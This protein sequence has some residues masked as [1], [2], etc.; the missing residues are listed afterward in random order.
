MWQFAEA[1]RG[2]ADGCLALG[3][4]VTGGNVSFY[5]QTGATAILPDPGRRRARRARRRHPPRPDGAARRR[6]RCSTCSATTRDEFGG[7]EWAHEV[8]GH[9]GGRPPAV[10]LAAERAL[11]EILIN[12]SRDGLLDAAHDLSDGGI[13]QALVEMAL[14]GGIGARVWVPDGLDPFVF[15]F[16]ESAARA[17]V[18][19]P[20]EEEVRFADM[21]TARRFPFLRIGVVD[22]DALDVQGQ[23]TVPL[24]DLRA[25]HEGT[26]PALFD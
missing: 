6:R 20:R 15:L 24:A 1:V 17:V 5:N 2:L 12:A 16:A 19:V 26:F 10:D 21:C 18:A 25:A 13:A 4:P 7:S 14:R 8:H 3:M 23:F 9:L 22:G 11:A